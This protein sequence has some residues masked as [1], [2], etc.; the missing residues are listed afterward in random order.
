[1]DAL[2]KQMQQTQSMIDD[3]EA[4]QKQLFETMETQ[5]KQK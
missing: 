2:D 4:A 3:A 5:L 1:M